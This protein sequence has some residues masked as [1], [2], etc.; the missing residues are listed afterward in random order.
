MIFKE[1]SERG[2]QPIEEL[3]FRELI[4]H[5]LK[6]VRYI[7]ADL[8]RFESVAREVD[9][10]EAEKQAKLCVRDFVT[11]MGKIEEETDHPADINRLFENEKFSD[12]FVRVVEEF[13][14][15]DPIGYLHLAVKTN[16]IDLRVAGADDRDREDFNDLLET[17]SNF[18]IRANVY[19]ALGKKSIK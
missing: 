4:E 12:G 19:K 17:A 10:F 13:Q 3:S 18:L 2:P 8:E 9:N 5:S 16:G 11:M 1:L 7:R 6:G 15:I 14:R